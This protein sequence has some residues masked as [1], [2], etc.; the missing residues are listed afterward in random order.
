MPVLC[1]KALVA[2]IPQMHRVRLAVHENRLTRTVITAEDYRQAIT[3]TGCG[4]VAEFDGVLR[5]F[6]VVNRD[7]RRVWALFVEPGFERQGIG[8]ALH[9]EMLQW[10]QSSGC[11][12]F[13][14]STEAGTRAE[15]FYRSAGWQFIGI[16]A[17]G[18]ACFEINLS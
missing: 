16:D 4:W 17:D 11:D 15:R 14:L 7:T 1:R 8:R 9:V 18:D 2:D 12:K 3:G 10:M 13:T 6:A 5:G